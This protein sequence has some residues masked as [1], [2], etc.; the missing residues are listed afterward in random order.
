MDTWAG[1]KKECKALKA[2]NEEATKVVF[3]E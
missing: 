1:H 3:V 2:K